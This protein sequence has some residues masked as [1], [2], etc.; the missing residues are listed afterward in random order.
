MAKISND[1]I[2]DNKAVAVSLTYIYGIGKT[3]ADKICKEV[4]VDGSRRVKDLSG[5]EIDKIS[6][7]IT[8]EYKTG[9]TL[10]REVFNNIKSLKDKKCYRGS[11]HTSGLPV[12]GQRTHTNA[13][14]SRRRKV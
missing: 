10:H 2:P 3:S 5:S 12:R 7:L 8:E 14:T 6:L 9:Q 11:R 13:R 4:G 1:I